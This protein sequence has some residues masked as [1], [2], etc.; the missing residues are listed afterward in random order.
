MAQKED[1]FNMHIR[2]LESHK[3]DYFVFSQ[4]WPQSQCYYRN[5]QTMDDKWRFT[6][7]NARNDC[8]PADVTTWTLHGLWPTVGG[9]AEPVNCNSSWPF[10]ESEIQD[11]ED[12]MMQRWLAFPDSSKSSARDLWSH[13][14]K[15]HGTCATD[16]AETSN[17]HSYFSMALA[18]NSN[19]GLL[20]AL[21]SE[22]II[23][24]DDQM[25][26]VKQVERAISNKYGAKGRVI[27]LR[28]PARDK[29]LSDEPKL[30]H[31]MLL[32]KRRVNLRLASATE[33]EAPRDSAKQAWAEADE[34]NTMFSIY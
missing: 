27:C 17:E 23:P 34:R 18:L 4:W 28:G 6:S 15:K 26:T 30:C 24:S 21:A 33:D 13:E 29:Q 16:L 10:V 32:L 31:V 14:W 8:V 19:C 5:G 7:G 3:W 2:S 22:N 11:L 12:R 20:R 9:K 1:A 25:Y